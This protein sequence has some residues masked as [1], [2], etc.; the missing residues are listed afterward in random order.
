MHFH[1]VAELVLFDQ[2]QGDFYADGVR[3]PLFPGAVVFVP[4][5]RRHD[6]DLAGGAK[7]WTLI[8]FDPFIFEALGGRLTRPFCARPGDAARCRIATLADWLV[9]ASA[10]GARDPTA[11]RIAELLLLAIAEAPEAEA[12]EAPGDSAAVER[13]LPAIERLRRAPGEAL[14]LE[15]AAAACHLSPAYFSHRFAQVMGMSFT[16]YVRTWRLHLAARHLVSSRAPVS[17]IAYRL[18]FS[19]PSH[20]TARFHERFGMT[21]REYRRNAS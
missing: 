15:D 1:D 16:D 8:Q 13:L 21:P 20:F 7:A 19:S 11:L 6:F 4:S 14:S 18:G 17:D 12:G 9:E 3:Y 10:A 2:V 5:M